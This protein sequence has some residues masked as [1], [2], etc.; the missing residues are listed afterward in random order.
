MA[1]PLVYTGKLVIL[2]SGFCVLTGLLELRTRKL[3]II[4]TNTATRW[5]T[6]MQ[7]GTSPSAWRLLGWHNDGLASVCIS[8]RS[9]GGERSS[10]TIISLMVTI[11]ACF[12]FANHLHKLL[13][14]VSI[15]KSQN[16]LPNASKDV[17][18]LTSCWKFKKINGSKKTAHLSIAAQLTT[19]ASVLIAGNAHGLTVNA[20]QGYIYVVN[21]IQTTELK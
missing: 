1:W 14:K 15:M 10:V 21:A 6:T 16:H 19:V 4:I 11:P 5:M 7:S 2:D 9:F 18:K 20:P 13:Y 3:S 17:W 8:A 12:P